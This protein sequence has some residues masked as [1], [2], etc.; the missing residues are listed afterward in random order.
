MTS[1]KSGRYVVIVNAPECCVLS[2]V[3]EMDGRRLLD[4]LA[5]VDYLQET[6]VA[7]AVASASVIGELEKLQAA[8]GR[9]AA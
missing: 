3:M 8:S 5:D 4:A 1:L 2:T 7:L 6:L 9:D